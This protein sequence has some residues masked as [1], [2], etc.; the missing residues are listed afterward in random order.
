MLGLVASR[1]FHAGDLFVRLT[2]DASDSFET[3]SA[4]RHPLSA[5]LF[6]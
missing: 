4:I 2:A 1:V 6:S 3:Q 5:S